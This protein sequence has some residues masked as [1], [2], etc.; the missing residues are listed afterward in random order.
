MASARQCNRSPVGPHR[1]RR[2]RAD[3]RPARHGALAALVRRKTGFDLQVFAGAVGPA[4]R[5]A[6]C[7]CLLASRHRN[8]SPAASFCGARR[9]DLI[10][11][12][13]A[14]RRTD[15]GGKAA[16]KRR[17]RAGRRK[18]H[19]ARRSDSLC[20]QWRG[21]RLRG[22][23]RCRLKDRRLLPRRLTRRSAPRGSRR[24]QAECRPKIGSELPLI[25]CNML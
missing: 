4:A 6:A 2:R 23:R 14:S 19:G 22:Q 13:E 5:L 17:R 24:P 8:G 3:D 16:G 1:S 15:A 10:L 9:E 18:R 12:G 25:S 21:R 7:P 11:T 20:E